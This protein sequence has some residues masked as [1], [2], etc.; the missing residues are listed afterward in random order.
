LPAEFGSRIGSGR[1]GRGDLRFPVIVG[2][3]PD[4]VAAWRRR[5]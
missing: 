5:R 2:Q 4:G 1:C 3:L